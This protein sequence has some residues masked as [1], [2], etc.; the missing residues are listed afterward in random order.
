[1]NDVV[2]IGPCTAGKS[3]LSRGLREQGFVAQIVAQEHSGIRA[4]W[5]RHE[6]RALVYLDVAIEQVHLRGRPGFPD[7]LLEQQQQRLASGRAAAHLYIDTTPLTIDTVLSTV[8]AFLL[9]Q[10]IIPVD[11]L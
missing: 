5:Q 8:L 9:D 11:H 4:L 3:T 7:W 1:M 10:Q 6:C 2:I